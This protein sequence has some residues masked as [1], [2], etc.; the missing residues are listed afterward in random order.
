MIRHTET[1]NR[2]AALNRRRLSSRAGIPNEAVVGMHV[3]DAANEGSF[4]EI[5]IDNQYFPERGKGGIASRV[6]SE[7]VCE[8]LHHKV[9]YAPVTRIE[10]AA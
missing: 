6:F 1:I 4:G 2:N 5:S 7:S 9:M 8:Q 10:G 3:I